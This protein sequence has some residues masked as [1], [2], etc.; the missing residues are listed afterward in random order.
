MISM[1]VPNII[2]LYILAPEIKRDLTEYCK[3]HKLFSKGE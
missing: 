3:K 2:V 1:C